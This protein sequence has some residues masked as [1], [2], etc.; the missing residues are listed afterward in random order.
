ME[1]QRREFL[2]KAGSAALFAALGINLLSC[3]SSDDT[4]PSG[5]GGGNTGGSSGITISGNNVSVDLSNTNN[6][7][8]G[9]AGSWRVLIPGQIILINIDGNNFR[10]FTSICT[11]Q[12]CDKDWTYSNNSQRLTCTC[13]GSIFSSVTGSV[14]NGPATAPLKEFQVSRVGATVTIIKS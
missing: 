5:G 7:A 2:M 14:I 9:N 6:T 4:G 3:S 11:H 10:A 8:L 1:N 13:H 12:A